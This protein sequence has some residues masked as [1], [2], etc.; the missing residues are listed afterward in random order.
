MKKQF[1]L[2]ATAVCLSITSLMAQQGMQRQTPEEK[3]KATMEK[4]TAF[5]LAPAAKSKTETIFT[6]FYKATQKAM[7]EMR[8]SGSDDREAFMAKRKELATERDAQLK[9]IF[10]QEQM[11]K[12]IDEIEPALRPQRQRN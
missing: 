3:T 4:L 11:K 7:Q 1:L 9:L 2:I 6:D 12:W 8:A 10:T 5:N